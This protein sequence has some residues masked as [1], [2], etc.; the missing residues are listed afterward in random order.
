MTTLRFL[1]GALAVLAVGSCASPSSGGPAVGPQVGG[2]DILR[3]VVIQNNV[4]TDIHVMAVVGSRRY[5]MGTVRGRSTRS[6]RVPSAVD[7]AS[8]RLAAE[9]R[10]NVSMASRIYSEPIPMSRV[11]EVTWD[12]R[13]GIASVI[14]GR[15]GTVQP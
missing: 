4:A 8:F 11:N 12:I 13:S 10:G 9:P 3:E 2:T 15:R 5:S 1:Y 6:L 7:V 14:Y